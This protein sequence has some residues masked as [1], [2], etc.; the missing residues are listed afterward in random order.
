MKTPVCYICMKVIGGSFVQ[1][2]CLHI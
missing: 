1:F 2:W